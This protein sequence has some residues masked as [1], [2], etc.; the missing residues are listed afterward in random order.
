MLRL[1]RGKSGGF[2]NSPAKVDEENKVNENGSEFRDENPKIMQP[3]SLDWMRFVDPALKEKQKEIVSKST[4]RTNE[5][6]KEVS[7]MGQ[8]EQRSVSRT[9]QS[10]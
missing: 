5:A 9:K 2:G 7:P 6:A 4:S 8:W 1:T 10:E 3:E